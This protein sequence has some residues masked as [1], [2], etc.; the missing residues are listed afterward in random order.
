MHCFEKNAKDK[1]ELCLEL[2]NGAVVYQKS[3][4]GAKKHILIEEHPSYL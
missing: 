1:Y 4:N 2:L 3:N